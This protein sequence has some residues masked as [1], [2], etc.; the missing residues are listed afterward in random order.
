[1]VSIVIDMLTFSEM[2]VMKRLL[3]F[4]PSKGEYAETWSTFRD[5]FG[6][7]VLDAVPCPN[8]DEMRLLGSLLPYVGWLAGRGHDINREC[9]LNRTNVEAFL[10]ASSG[11]FT[12]GSLRTYRSVLVSAI[13]ALGG[14]VE[15]LGGTAKFSRSVPGDPYT[16]D[17][18]GWLALWATRRLSDYTRRNTKLAV[19]LGLGAGLTSGEV[20]LLDRSS[21]TVSD[22]G[23]NVTVPHGRTVTIHRTFEELF[24]GAFPLGDPT[25]PLVLA[26]AINRD[27]KTLNK[28]LNRQRRRTDIAVNLRK[29]R[30]T[31]IVRHLTA[32]TPAD[33]LIEAAGVETLAGLTRFMQFVPPKP[34]DAHREFLRGVAL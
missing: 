3:S 4:V 13:E 25:G 19:A 7:L 2:D 28:F 20:M 8:V 26:D 10:S 17:E 9:V 5:F 30:T 15:P 31:W 27:C 29:M 33:V 16:D 6:E 21:V 18:Q 12:G 22:D 11:K 1:M 23:V 34:A 32:G 14:E 24:R